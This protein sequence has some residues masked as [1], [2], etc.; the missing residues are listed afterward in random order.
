MFG[1]RPDVATL[2]AAPEA[3]DGKPRENQNSKSADSI[4]QTSKVSRLCLQ[5]AGTVVP[6]REC[7]TTAHFDVQGSWLVA[8]AGFGV[9][10]WSCDPG[11]LCRALVPSR[12]RQVTPPGFVSRIRGFAAS[13]TVFL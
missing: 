12:W 2:N 7:I 4:D 1:L 11:L 3:Q 6:L 9:Q 10:L 8:R 13:H 5:I